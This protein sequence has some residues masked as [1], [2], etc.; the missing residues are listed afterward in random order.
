[1]L[2]Q[3]SVAR[4]NAGTEKHDPDAAPMGKYRSAPTRYAL[5]LHMANTE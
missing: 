2:Y 5:S 1:M 4:C 3:I